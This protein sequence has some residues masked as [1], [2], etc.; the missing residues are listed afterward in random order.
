MRIVDAHQSMRMADAH[1]PEK[2]YPMLDS[3]C[4]YTLHKRQTTIEGYKHRDG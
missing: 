3:P 4:D 2:R 1:Q